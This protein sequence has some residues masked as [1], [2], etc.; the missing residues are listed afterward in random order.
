MK[1]LTLHT[2]MVLAA[3]LLTSAV[4]LCLD[5]A[6]VYIVRNY[7]M[8][9]FK[10]RITFL[11]KYLAVNAEV[12][13]LIRDRTGLNSLAVNLLGE[14]DVALVAVMDSDYQILV[15]QS[16]NIPGDLYTV[17]T[18]IKLNKTDEENILFTQ[19]RETPFG[20]LMIKGV[21]NI[22]KVK[23]QYSTRGINKLIA[24]ITKQFVMVSVIL[25]FFAGILFYF[26]VKTIVVEVTKL[27]TVSRMIGDG[28]QELRAEPGTL[29]ETRELAS[30]FNSMLDSIEKSRKAYERITKEAAHQKSLAELGKFSL[31]VAHEVKN[32]LAIIKSA[33]EFL[34]KEYRI[35]S[36]NTMCNYIDDEIVRINKLIEDFLVFAKPGNVSFSDICPKSLLKMVYSR[37]QILYEDSTVSIDLVISEDER[38]IRADA[39]L[40]IRALDNIVKN[41]VEA[42]PENGK[43]T[44]KSYVENDLWFVEIMDQ[45]SGIN[46]GA[47]NDIF[48]PFF[49]T[50]SKGTG[51]GLALA[52]QIIKAHNGIMY[53]GNGKDSGAVF[54]LGIPIVL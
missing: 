52:Y 11:A 48:E 38:K 18:Q 12:G 40:L 36:D 41:A 13:V 37:Y 28:N 29:P 5:V 16:R 42:S 19:H 4:T 17:E 23:I 51:L 46:V 8:D 53:A 14:E 20:T 35:S 7:M 1:R 9:R 26:M 25:T 43:V 27:A 24:R 32:P 22:G 2:R 50:K 31:S 10:E 54:T 34:K 45:G 30:A 49:T 47:E 3:L 21:E 44:I 6:G 33:F 39:N 15:E